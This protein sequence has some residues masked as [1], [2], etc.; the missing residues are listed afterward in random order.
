MEKVKL[1][2][3]KLSDTPPSLIYFVYFLFYTPTGGFFL[4]AI[5]LIISALL[6]HFSAF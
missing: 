6:L 2:E 4:F 3:G 5:V 1:S